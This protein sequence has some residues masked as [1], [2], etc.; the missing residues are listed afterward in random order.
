[1]F[2][3]WEKRDEAQVPMTESKTQVAGNRLPSSHFQERPRICLIDVEEDICESLKSAGFNC[4]VGTFGSVVEVPNRKRNDTHPCLLNSRFPPNLHEYDIVVID[5][6]S[7]RRTQYRPEDHTPSAT[8]GQR[9][10]VFV[11]S[12]PETLFDPRP[13]ASMILQS[14]LQP[15]LKRESLFII[16]A[17]E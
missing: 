7:H 15:L 12:F 17:T 4:F 1:M 13:L 6:Q 5:L 14:C 2:R 11:S 3:K 9:Q 10:L 16:F 8:R